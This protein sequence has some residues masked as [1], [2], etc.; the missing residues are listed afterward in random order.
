MTEL[1]RTKFDRKNIPTELLIDYS[2]TKSVKCGKNQSLLFVTENFQ[3]N[4]FTM[5]YQKKIG[6]SKYPWKKYFGQNFQKCV[7]NSVTNC[8]NSSHNF[9]SKKSMKF[10]KN[11]TITIFKNWSQIVANCVLVTVFGQKTNKIRKRIFY[12]HNFKKSVTNCDQ[13]HV[14]HNFQSEITCFVTQLAI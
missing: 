13:L 9:R 7:I 6:F 2:V 1:W 3:P 11:I 4:S 8:D 5:V 10:V 12:G 14:G